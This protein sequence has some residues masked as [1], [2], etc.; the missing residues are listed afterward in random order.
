M[1]YPPTGPQA[2]QIVSLGWDVCCVY[3]G[4]PRS[5]AHSAWHQV[6]NVSYPVR[7]LSTIF[8]DF[9]P[10]Y[11][12]RNQPWDTQ[13]NFLHLGASDGDD[14]N[15]QTGA[16]GFGPSTPICLDLES[17]TYARWPRA[18]RIYCAAWVSQVNAAGHKAYLY[19]DM[20]TIQAIG[21]PDLFDGTFVAWWEQDALRLIN[22]KVS[23]L[24]RSYDPSES[25]PTDAWQFG[26]G[27]TASVSVDFDSFSD[28]MVLAKYG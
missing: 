17:G 9:L 5:A 15:I 2:R 27:Y 24:G 1:V 28:G 16:C 26:G 4:G 7:D 23:E 20:Q 18:V 22:P 21:Q 3:I 6:D 11:V 14:A 25:P 8:S 10:I 12:G 13:S 19:S